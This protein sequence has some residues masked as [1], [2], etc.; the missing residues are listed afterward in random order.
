MSA[1]SEAEAAEA[2]STAWL[3]LGF[4]ELLHGLGEKPVRASHAFDV[5]IVGSG[6]GGAVAASELAG[7]HNERGEPA[8]VCVLE[9]G[10][11]YLPGMFPSRLTDL[12]GHVRF[13]TGGSSAPRGRRE[14]LFDIRVGEDVSAVL[15]N[16]LGGGSLINAGVMAR[17][18]GA[19]FA[20]WPAAVAADLADTY[21]TRAEKL[22]E[23]PGNTLSVH[24]VKN[25]MK[26]VALRRL[27]PGAFKQTEITVAMKS[28]P[29]QEKVALER[30]K[31]CGDCATGCNHQ[32][33]NSLDVSLL[34]KARRAGA[35][36]FTG[37]TVLRIERDSS[38]GW[39]V[40]TVHTDELLRRRQ[41]RV[42]KLRTRKVILA[43]GTFGS[44]EILLRSQS[45]RLKFS[46]LL[47]QRFSSN[48]DAIAVAY[49]QRDPVNAVAYECDAP[50]ARE[51]GPTIT[52]MLDLRDQAGKGYVI[53]EIAIPG[54]L[55]RLFEETV[56]TANA[57]HDLGERDDSEHRKDDRSRDPCSVDPAAILNTS[58]VV[59]MGDDGAAGALELVGGAGELEG[60]GA[61]RVRWP[62]LREQPLFPGQLEKL[63]QLVHDSPIGG[64]VLANPLWQLL[65]DSMQF[66]FDSK[67][68][69]LLTVHPLGGCPM[70]SDAEKGVVNDLGQV[71]DVGTGVDSACWKDLAVLDGAVVRNALGINPALTITAV[72]LRA[73]EGLRREWSYKKASPA[74]DLPARPIFRVPKVEATRPTE[75]RLIE[76]MSGD[77]ELKKRGWLGLI[78]W[79]GTVPC[80]IELTLKFGKKSVEELTRP[81]TIARTLDV[82]EG[83]LR[84][85][86]KEKWDK[87][88][89]DGGAEKEL[90]ELAAVTVP[91]HGKLTLLH[92][93]GST[94][95]KRRCRALWA[96]WVNRGMRDSWHWIAKRWREG[97]LWTRESCQQAKERGSRSRAL[98]SRAGEVRRLEYRLTLGN[99]IPPTRFALRDFGA[100][101]EVHGIKRLTYDRRCNPWR[102]LMQL[103]LEKF[104]GLGRRLFGLKHAESEL[105]LDAKYLADQR[106][107]LMKVV[108]Q[109]D[110][111]S[112][113]ADLG[114][115][116][117]YF[118][119]LL[120]NI[121]V[122][123][124]RRP[125]EA[126]PR[127]PQRLPAGIPRGRLP[128]P[129]IKELE[130]DR[131]PDGTPVCV[132]LTRYRPRHPRG[133]PL[134]LVHGYSASG[135]TFAHHALEPSMAE[136][137]YK[138]RRDVWVLDLRTS[139]GMPTARYPWAFEQ[140]ALE[141][142]PAA[143]EE[144]CRTR[145]QEDGRK[146]S[147]IKVDVFAHCMGSA[148]FTMAVLGWPEAGDRF[149]R[150]RLALPGRIR[151]AVLS[152]IAPVVVM[153][154][155]N[156]FRGYAMSYLRHFL[157]LANYQFRV[158]PDP[159]LADQLIDRLLATLPYPKEEFDIENPLW[160]FS[161]TRFVGTRHRM[162]ALYGR[163]FSLAD[164][165][166]IPLLSA[167]VLDY[168]DDLFGPLNMETVAQ[169]IHFARS[170]LITNRAGRNEYVLP[171]NLSRRW[172]F[173]TA[174]IHGSEN[175]LSDV[176]TLARFAQR[177]RQA[178]IHVEPKEFK[179]FG[180]QDSL[181]GKRAREVF[182]Y[183]YEFF[184]R[185]D[186]DPRF[187][188]PGPE[189]A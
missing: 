44:T 154:P 153:S 113:L 172:L 48:G 56:T 120:L 157:P 33:K 4:E 118:L 85:F 49:R 125:D 59:M 177:F 128:D 169:A 156:I 89:H 165:N 5:V 31:L 32:A 50:D 174:S 76:R 23:V 97:K 147:N 121:H 122:W 141:D 163:D 155:A 17:P 29:N 11:E 137:F 185:E 181:I 78:P 96:W 119:R 108:G 104:P 186:D 178:G 64:R 170:E 131:L 30:C 45:E 145:E 7:Y 107:P 67:H 3:S 127:E 18:A 57:L 20:G 150:E 152:Q 70:G 71:F 132:R 46:S 6:Y 72:A 13:N 138:G 115:F 73:V 62:E 110:Q 105:E 123:S 22:L 148:M 98:A 26:A 135:T 38:R 68:G 28:G 171:L 111:V 168:I 53:Q 100:G 74:V 87:W 52:G 149:Y 94:Y 188:P 77:A 130:L 79:F 51:V 95:K 83:W 63:R 25:V 139:S 166:G 66:L 55:R 1:G 27:A 167:E 184:E 129:H 61:V 92:R 189:A 143:I 161:Y 91:L 146:S 117:A 19:A 182:G 82:E 90:V 41:K 175:D 160:P 133:V 9:R 142:I 12:A 36:I 134:V 69:P 93:E 158:G 43:A 88:R 164:K 126:V 21:F 75:L 24:P 35:H 42:A 34:V 183:V 116:A 187:R 2:C 8:S 14:G 39:L 106:V 81:V 10:R 84:I 99:P 180:H 86:D 16:G 54:S 47:G 162:D 65:P 124:F 136:Y 40:H 114:S 103:R 176:A 140:A 15:A 58:A 179:G 173:P 112:A 60:D 109:N 102:Q 151:R 37:A 144:I 159:G 101:A 80:R